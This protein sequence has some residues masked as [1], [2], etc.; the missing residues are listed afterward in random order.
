MPSSLRFS[1]TASSSS[2]FSTETTYPSPS[3]SPIKKQK[4]MSLTQTYYLAHTARAKL[5]KEARRADHDLRLLVGHANLLDGLMLDLADAEREQESWFNQS[6]K[7]AAAQA[8][9]SDEPKH[10]QW[11]DS[12][13]TVSE[14]YEEEDSSDD[15]SDASDDDDEEESYYTAAPL[16]RVPSP[17]APIQTQQPHLPTEMDIDIDS[18]EEEK[19]EDEDSQDLVLTRTSS[20]SPP[21]LLHESDSDSSDDENSMP[22]S[23]PALTPLDAFSAKQRQAALFG[24]EPADKNTHHHHPQPSHAAIEH[25]EADFYEEGYYLPQRAGVPVY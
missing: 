7:G 20:R 6:V 1:S 15:E 14:D 24:S 22:P 21:D 10:I 9:S 8:S 25:V 23:P 18:E 13:P 19:D 16:R 5:S 2:A 3:Q 4:K 12:L 11:A 17:P